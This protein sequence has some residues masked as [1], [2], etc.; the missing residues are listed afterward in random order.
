MAASTGKRK[1]V[2]TLEV[3]PH[4]PCSLSEKLQ[5]FIRVKLWGH[6][7]SRWVGHFGQIGKM[8]SNIIIKIDKIRTHFNHG[9]RQNKMLIWFCKNWSKEICK[10]R[11]LH[12]RKYLLGQVTTMILQVFV[13]FKD[14]NCILLRQRGTP[15]KQNF[16]YFQM[17]KW[18]LLTTSLESVWKRRDCLF[19][20]LVL[21]LSYS[22]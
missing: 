2:L 12:H 17:Q 8:I 20:L 16:E 6:G 18:K 10:I 5:K 19:S 15:W 4:T 3:Q 1:K 9:I 21:L 14:Q 13:Y 22:P 7:L 11:K